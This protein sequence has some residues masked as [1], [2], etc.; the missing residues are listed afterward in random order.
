[1]LA[2]HWTWWGLG[3]FYSADPEESGWPGRELI[4]VLGP[5][6]WHICW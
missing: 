2:A 3:W 1:M 6:S 5:I 4:L